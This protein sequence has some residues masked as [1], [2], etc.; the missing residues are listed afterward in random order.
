MNLE[1]RIANHTMQ[2]FDAMFSPRTDRRM[3]ETLRRNMEDTEIQYEQRV[4]AD[5]RMVDARTAAGM[6]C[7]CD[8]GLTK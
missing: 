2:V 3:T 1:T 5:R 7:C 4:L 8:E 6:F